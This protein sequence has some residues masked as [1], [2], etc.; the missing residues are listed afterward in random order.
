MSDRTFGDG[1]MWALASL[2]AKSGFY[3]VIID[4]KAKLSICKCKTIL[5]F[6]Y[7]LLHS[8]RLSNFYSRCSPYSSKRLAILFTNTSSYPILVAILNTETATE[9]AKHQNVKAEVNTAKAEPATL[10]PKQRNMIR[11]SS[12]SLCLAWLPQ[13]IPLLCN[14][15]FRLSLRINPLALYYQ[16]IISH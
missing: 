15:G 7:Q 11:I 2:N 16:G 12:F 8:I 5:Y 6:N 3:T 9:Y 14:V 10:K 1:V 13:F 4:N